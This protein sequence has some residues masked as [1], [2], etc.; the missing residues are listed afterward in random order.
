VRRYVQRYEEIVKKLAAVGASATDAFSETVTAFI[1]AFPVKAVYEDEDVRSL[2]ADDF[3]AAITAFRLF[4]GQSKDEFTAALKKE[5]GNHGIGIKSFR[6]EPARFLA[7]LSR[8]G[9]QDAITRTVSQPVTWQ[10]ILI[11]RL[12]AGRGRA[13]KGQ[14]RGRRLEDFT[15]EIVQGIFGER[16]RGYD[17]RCRFIG[18]TGTSSEKADFAIPRKSNPRV[19][20]EVKAYGATG[21]KQTDVL[22]D[23]RRIVEQK[24]HDTTL[25]LVTDGTTW[26]ARANDLR[27]LVE[28]QNQGYIARIYTMAM[29]GELRKDL[30]G[31]KTE[32]GL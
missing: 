1:R 24:R 4:L 23:M 5:L 27:K 15:E 6:A 31:L 17:V 14:T 21:S 25:L 2:L 19:L 16:G 26:V 11:E 3:D 13:I 32:H 10:D 22:G 18:R 8:L 7:A 28:M 12:T 29:A 30:K 9:L 20:I